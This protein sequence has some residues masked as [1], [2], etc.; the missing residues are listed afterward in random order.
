MR[1]RTPIVRWAVALVL[2]AVALLSVSASA[3]AALYTPGTG[4]EQAFVPK[5][6][7]TYASTEQSYVVP[8]GV[9]QLHVLAV[10]ASGES[11]D[12]P[13]GA[14]AE[15]TSVLDVYPGEVLWIVFERGAGPAVADVPSACPGYTNGVYTGGNEWEYRYGGEGGGD[16]E[17]RTVAPEAE[18]HVPDESLESRVLVAGGGGGAG[19]ALR[20]SYTYKLQEGETL[21]EFQ[22]EFDFGLTEPGRFK[23]IPDSKGGSG[24]SGGA[25]GTPGPAGSGASGLYSN[26]NNA[27]EVAQEEVVENGGSAYLVPIEVKINEAPGPDSSSGGGGGGGYSGEEAGGPGSG[28][29]AGSDGTQGQAALFQAAGTGG[30]GCAGGGGGGAGYY[31]GGGGG[32][33]YWS[34]GGGGAGASYGPT[35]TSFQNAGGAYEREVVVWATGVAPEVT[36]QPKP[37]KVQEPAAAHFSAACIGAPKPTLRWEQSEPGA[38]F[39]PIPGATEST[40]TLSPT[41]LEESGNEYRVT[42]ENE[43]G[44]KITSDAAALTVQQGRPSVTEVEPAEG[45]LSGGTAVKIIGTGFANVSAVKV[46]SVSAKNI[47]VVSAHEITAESPPDAGGPGPVDVTV[48]TPGGESAASTADY[49][50]YL[51]SPLETRTFLARGQ[52][53]FVVPAGVSE[54]EVTATGGAGSAGGVCEDT[55]TAAPGGAGAKVTA[56]LHVT[57]GQKLYVGFSSGGAAGSGYCNV[58]GGAGG[59]SSDLR[60]KPASAGTESL[61]SRLLVAG[62]GGGGGEGYGELLLC[63]FGKPQSCIVDADWYGGAGGNAGPTG[64]SGA[65]SPSGGEGGDGGG[66]GAPGLGGGIGPSSAEPG[67]VGSLGE[68]GAGGYTGGGG[69]AGYYGGG[70]GS[71]NSDGGGGGGGGSSYLDEGHGKLKGAIE[72]APGQTQELVVTYPARTATSITTSLSGGGQTGE[73][74]TV[75]EGTAVSD[76]ATLGG[77]SAT[78]ATGSVDYQVY[79]DSECK[80]PAA[81]ADAVEVAGGVVP[82]SDPQTLAPGI[83]YWQ[84]SYSGDGGNLESTSLCGAEVEKVAAPPIAT[85]G[86]PGEGGVYKQGESVKT[87]FSCTES[88]YG[89]GIATCED[90]NKASG[91][92][93]ELKTTALGE[94]EYTVTATSKDGQT[95]ATT[96]KYKVAAPPIA[97]IGSPG[98]GG[99]YKQGESVKTTFSCTES[100]YGSGIATCEDSNKASGGS[101]ELKTAALGEHEYTVTATSKDGQ[102]TATTIKYKVAAPPIATIGSPG[103][104]GVYEQ[105]ESVKTTFSCTESTYGSGLATCEDSNKAS[106]GSG[107]LKTVEPGEHEYTVTATS[108]DGQT[109]TTGI[110]YKVEGVPVVDGEAGNHHVG[111][112]TASLSTK[113]AGDLVVAF[114]EADG[115][116]GPGNTAK[117]SGGGLSWS[118]AGRENA[119]LGDAE[120]WEARATSALKEASVTATLGLGGYEAVLDVVAFR[121][122]TGLGQLAGFSSKAGAPAGHLTGVRAGSWVWAVGDD[123]LASEAREAGAAQTIHFQAFDATGDTYWVQSTTSP[124][125]NGGEVLI[126]DRKPTGDP[127][128]L[129]LA[130]ILGGA[131]RVEE[132]QRLKGESTYTTAKLSGNVGQLVEYEITA[133]NTD[134]VPLTLT[135]KDAGC[136]ALGG[137]PGAGTVPPGASVTWTCTHE[138]TATGTYSNEASVQGSEGIGSQVSNRVEVAVP[139]AV[140][141][142]FA[143]VAE[144]K[145]AGEA[146]YTSG[147]LKG[148]VG[149]TVDYQITATDTG[150]VALKF[151]GFTDVGCAGITGGPGAG[152]LAAG[153]STAWTCTRALTAPGTYTDEASVEGSEGTGKQTSKPVTVVVPPASYTIAKEQKLAGEAAYTKSELVA[154]VGQTVDYQITVTNAG[155]VP[156]TF[157]HFLDEK[158]QGLEGGPTAPAPVTSNLLDTGTPAIAESTDSRAVVLGVKFTSSTA[159]Y[160][161][162]VRFYKAAGNIGTHIGSLWSSSGVKLA[163]ATFT[164]ETAGGWQTVSFEKPVAIEAGKTYI[165]SYLAPKGHYSET[166]EGF[167]TAITSPPLTAPASTPTSPNGVYAYAATNIFPSSTYKATNYWVDVSFQSTPPG[168]PLAPGQSTTWTCHHTLTTEGLYTN[169]ASIEGNEGTGKQASNTVTARTRALP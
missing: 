30:N 121:D 116:S 29:S 148:V 33:G 150:T 62:G 13:G 118:F 94:H 41:L 11:I 115:P 82:R 4:I 156:L 159:G 52:Q 114:V 50:T 36:T 40:L 77:A 98:E 137:G 141:K 162:G 48:T 83:Y 45:P 131:L 21:A 140:V 107:E 112:V 119:A 126:N 17:V 15:A 100:T 10:G 113:S 51:E 104:G 101:G 169:Q 55:V 92:S 164:G 155:G 142:S 90:S 89:S 66:A 86:S 78:K 12:G 76:G 37:Q 54:I 58:S 163:E 152:A 144:Q 158:C 133:T 129:E 38:S 57:P 134:D 99:V 31:P 110:K 80:T 120:V 42:C 143:L 167:E 47:K 2:A 60:E 6:G 136:G 63:E 125:L 27:E 165:A 103:E 102:T 123:W 149:Q 28:G 93:G 35:G 1:L 166:L 23:Y 19:G 87:T 81:P 85:I 43:N 130:E 67:G 138:L 139:P 97:T 69:G 135:A 44:E 106:G 151:S 25:A 154:D 147:A 68:G 168:S 22:T 18:E 16:A 39:K 88:T 127:F 84:A 128:N 74:I 49:F 75:P 56:L 70:G 105:G 5:Y 161:T 96:I 24:G 65:T 64:H 145:L 91:G 9:T 95:T 124:T 157:S 132:L 53:H 46:G 79:S 160:V 117:V 14:G 34:G 61:R 146:N 8:P 3:Y 20:Q 71:G 153:A 108:K 32:G 7:T 26:S 122:A 111:S 109:T 73:E 72:P 59:G